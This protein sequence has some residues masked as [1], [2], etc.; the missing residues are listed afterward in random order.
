MCAV[1]LAVPSLSVTNAP[2]MGWPRVLT[3]QYYSP[4]SLSVAGRP[5]GMKCE[6]HCKTAVGLVEMVSKHKTYRVGLAG[7][8]GVTS[9]Y[10]G[11]LSGI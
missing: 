11:N 8:S 4:N 9:R 7:G 2:G 3:G 10:K 6:V 1:N 5:T